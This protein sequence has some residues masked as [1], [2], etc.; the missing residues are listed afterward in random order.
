MTDV[1]RDDTV[2]LQV[3]EY[4]KAL[5]EAVTIDDYG[6]EFDTVE[7]GPLSANDYKSRYSI[8]IVPST[9][10]KNWQFPIVNALMTVAI[11]F[12]LVRQREDA[13]FSS[14]VL[15]ERMLGVV[16]QVMLDDMN[17]GG[18]VVQFTET[19]NAVDAE[20]YDDRTISGVVE[21]N[22]LYRHANRNV[23]DPNPTV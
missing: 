10:A 7:L 15:G 6:I 3:L 18:L 22:I 14:V 4:I 12:R 17:L 23:Y 21:W 1:F 19:S 9:E 13:E 11:E 16:Q 8:G 20:T 5:Y 2:R